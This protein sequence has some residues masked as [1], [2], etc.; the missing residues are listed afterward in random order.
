MP[1]EWNEAARQL[2]LTNGHLSLVL[3]AF[4]S[5]DLGQLHLG[6]PLALGRDYSHLGRGTF[7]GF[8][9]RVAD[10]TR[11]ALPTRGSGDFRVPAI[12]VR[13]ADG[14]RV[15]SLEYAGHR[16]VAGKPS[17]DP[18]P[19]TYT[20]DPAEAETVEITLVD[21]L[22]GIEVALA[23]TIFRDHA[24]IARSMV[25]RNAG[26]TAATILT[27]MS[28]SID[29]PDSDWRMVQ[30]SGA[31]ARER[32]V[33]ERA[34]VPGLQSIGSVRGA[35][36]AHQNPFLA[37]RRPHTTESTGEAI[38]LSLIHAG[39]FLAEV[40]VD[41]WGTA[42]ARIG[43]H[44]DGF[45]WTLEPS[46]AFQVPEA[47]I[48]WTADGLGAMSDTF[49]ELYRT[50]LARGPWRDRE[51][52][53]LLNNWEGTYFDFDADRI[54]AIAQ[55]SKDLGAELFVLDDG[56]FGQRNDDHRALGDWYVNTAKLPG[57]LKALGERVTALG[58]D[59]GIWIE[60]E[61]VNADSD[62]FRAHP[63]WA[64][65]VPGRHRTES[66][67][68]LVLDLSNPVVVD[69][70]ATVIIDV[71]K[72]ARISYIKWDFNRY[73]TEPWTPTLPAER[74]GEFHHRWVLGLYEL[75]RRLIAAFPDVLFESCASGGGRFDPALLAFAPQGWTSDDTDA[76]ERLKIQW[77]TSL[78]YPISSMGAHVSAVPNHQVG[79][80]EPLSTR[81]AVAFSGAFGYELD[82]T[83]LT[84]E[85]KAEVRDQIA[86]FKER[87]ALLQL[88][89]FVRLRS[90]FEGD[91]NET[92]WMSVSDDGAHAVV[93]WVRVLAKPE[94]GY[95]TLPL[96]GLDPARTYRITVWPEDPWI[97]MHH[98][99][100]RGGDDLMA[101]GLLLDESRAYATSSGD[102]L[103]R[104]FELTAID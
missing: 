90:P 72:D 17:T 68:Q 23:L 13:H 50:R 89:R 30:L 88:G 91:G 83:R 11:F 85:E 103:G 73:L 102:F 101:N 80:I 4:E 53:V 97:A 58:L 74:Q 75:Y 15:L 44:P 104:L 12:E 48:A 46:A 55:A 40:E 22:S 66:R 27:A 92:A 7:P 31:W 49:H 25:V 28:A 64:V 37:L 6:A 71:L 33:V 14:S 95:H 41:H 96:R 38:G 61:M 19:S 76:I 21:R 34:L 1:I 10:P 65:G 87:R 35:S 59:F 79:R 78:V 32:H 99:A 51:R 84:D 18:L 67:Q 81:A 43:I 20:E 16:I 29:L 77:G 82:P 36:S 70:L 52:P 60:P 39:N 45:A 24:A 42:R 26:R 94:P 63:D 47:V 2:H 98:P 57:G 100:P 9:N 54:V 56:W 62:L 93:T 8:D 69:H 86:W 5:G 3:R